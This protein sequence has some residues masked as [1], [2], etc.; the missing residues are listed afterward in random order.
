MGAKIYTVM[1][2]DSLGRIDNQVINN[3]KNHCPEKPFVD[4]HS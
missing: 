4:I 3:E 1:I 2:T